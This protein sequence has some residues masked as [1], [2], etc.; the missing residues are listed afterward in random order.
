MSVGEKSKAEGKRKM[1]NSRVLKVDTGKEK[2]ILWSQQRLS[3]C[4]H[5]EKML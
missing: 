4:E 1:R 5:R 3:A 2:K